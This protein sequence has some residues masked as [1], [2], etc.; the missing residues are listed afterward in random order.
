MLRK[1]IPIVGVLLLVAVPSWAA[2][3]GFFDGTT[4]G[5]NSLT[6]VVG[7]VGWALD[8][9]GIA[10]VDLYVDGVIDGRMNFGMQ[11]V[12]VTQLYPGYPDTSLPGFGYKVDTTRYLNGQHTLMTIAVSTD[13]SE[14]VLGPISVEF[15]NTTA[16]LKP[17]GSFTFPDE[18]AELRGVCDLAD[19]YRRYAVIE[20]FALDAGVEVGN[21]DDPPGDAGVSVVELLLD[22][23]LLYNSDTDCHFDTAEG[24]YSQC[25]GLRSINLERFYRTL[26]DA[27]HANFRFVVD[28]G[29]LIYLGYPQGSHVFSARAH[30]V[31][32]NVA[33]IDQQIVT[34]QCDENTGNEASFGTLRYASGG[35]SQSGMA[36]FVGWTLDWEGVSSVDIY[37][38]GLWLG[39]ANYGAMRPMIRSRYPG[40]PDSNGPGYSFTI[41]TTLMADGQH[42]I[43]SI[44]T[45]VFGE[46]TMIAER[47]IIVMNNAP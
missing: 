25:Y 29:S 35:I 12:V 43:Q 5:S 33:T 39:T 47:T 11:R 18:H 17:F 40:Y 38:D 7:L 30:D 9:S 26:P 4:D 37:V 31:A 46:T 14:T 23:A 21:P 24:G 45:D 42:D 41:D 44:V 13:G 22:G 28:V 27:P 10:Y 19:P 2:P 16:L 8:D 15:I 3:F 6:G 1:L 32:G 36:Q 20:G 34:F